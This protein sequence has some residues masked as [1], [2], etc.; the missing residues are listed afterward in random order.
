MENN[1]KELARLVAAVQEA[2][3]WMLKHGMVAPQKHN[4]VIADVL[5]EF[6]EVQDIEYYLDPGDKRIEVILYISVWRLILLFLTFRTRHFLSSIL[7]LL[8]GHFDGYALRVSVRRASKL[9]E[10]KNDGERSNNPDIID[11]D[12]KALSGSVRSDSASEQSAGNPG[13]DQTSS[14]DLSKVSEEGRDSSESDKE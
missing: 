10:N 4:L 5:T 6:K 7:K 12:Y 9:K 13:S 11:G 2:E 14:T 1:A 8:E 3:D